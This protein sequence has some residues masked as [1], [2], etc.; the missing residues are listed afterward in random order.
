MLARDGSFA[1]NDYL[2]L[3]IESGITGVVIYLFLLV[4]LI[5]RNDAGS[6]SGIDPLLTGSKAGILSMAVC[7][8]FSYPMYIVQNLLLLFIYASFISSQSK[9]NCRIRLS[10]LWYYCFTAVMGLFL[11]LLLFYKI[12]EY[13]A[14]KKWKMAYLYSEQ[15]NIREA[16]NIYEEVYPLLKNRPLFLFNYGSQ[17]SISGYSEKSVH[18]LQSC[19]AKQSSYDAYLNLAKSYEDLNNLL[20]AEKYYQKCSSLIPHRFVPKYRLFII[21]KKTHRCREAREMANIIINMDIKVY[22]DLVGEIRNEAM[23]YSCT[24]NGSN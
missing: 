22:S 12:R 14:C 16:L 10:S 19:I 17:L 6:S 11:V 7:S 4:L 5:K 21:Y 8:L 20:S 23:K 15:Q 18:V 2:Q 1:Y 9:S 3:M 13:N 24:M